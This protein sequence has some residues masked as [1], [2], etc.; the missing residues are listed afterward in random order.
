MAR[1]VDR[2]GATR[3]PSKGEWA[4]AAASTGQS[5]WASRHRPWGPSG[6]SRSTFTCT[7]AVWHIIR[8]PAGPRASK[9]VS[10]AS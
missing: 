5:W 8:L 10:M 4:K 1:R 6:P 2:H 9:W 3:P 7:A